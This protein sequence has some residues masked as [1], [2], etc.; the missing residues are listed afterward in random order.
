MIHVLG[1][2]RKSRTPFYCIAGYLGAVLFPCI[3]TVLK[4]KKTC[5]LLL[6]EVWWLQL[7]QRVF[8]DRSAMVQ[9]WIWWKKQQEALLGTCW[10]P[11]QDCL[12]LVPKT[13][14]ESLAPLNFHV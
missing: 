6:F 7:G 14:P 11:Q 13:T 9:S 3:T 10:D 5:S 12:N 1:L 8:A 4:S 2:A